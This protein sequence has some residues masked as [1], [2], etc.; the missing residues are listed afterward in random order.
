MHGK[1]GQPDTLLYPEGTACAEVLINGEKGGTSGATVFIGF[2]IAFA[3]KFLTETMT[4]LRATVS[5]P[6]GFF[7]PAAKVA[8]DMASELLGVGYILGARIGSIMMAGA[9]MGWLVVIPAIY[10]EGA[11][12]GVDPDG[13]YKNYLRY[14]GAGCVAAAGIISMIRTLPM[15]VRSLLGNPVVQHHDQHGETDA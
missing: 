11:K 6:L 12:T 1:P 7:S 8:G 13:V 9:V 3:H 15:I 5:V 10:L 14:I 2:G 4:L